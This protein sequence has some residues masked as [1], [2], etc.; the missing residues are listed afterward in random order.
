MH[1]LFWSIPGLTIYAYATNILIQHGFYSYFGIPSDFINASI[2]TNIINYFGLF[3]LVKATMGLIVWWMW[4]ILVP[5]ILVL[6]FLYYMDSR[7]QKIIVTFGTLVLIF[8]LYTSFNFGIQLAKGS[9]FFYA[10]IS[11]CISKDG[12]E[13]VIPGFY[14]DKAILVSI[15]PNNKM[16]GG[17]IVRDLAQISCELNFQRI[18]TITK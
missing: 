10:P 13:Y 9:E 3:Q 15:D 11:N 17:F 1:K 8:F 5:I 12:T 7:Y 2:T 18:G 4:F 14:Q 16:R 6:V